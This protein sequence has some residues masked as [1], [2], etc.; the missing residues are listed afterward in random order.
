MRNAAALDDHNLADAARY[1]FRVWGNQEEVWRQLADMA[2]AEPK[3]RL[4]DCY[5]IGDDPSLNTK[6]RRSRLKVKHLREERLGFQRWSTSWH[7]LAEEAKEELLMAG[8]APGDPLSEDYEQMLTDTI[9]DLEWSGDVRPVLVTKHRRRFRV[10]S[11]RAESTT[12]MVDGM[13]KLLRTIAIEGYDLHD[14][15]HLRAVLGLEHVPNLPL[16]TAVNRFMLTAD[17]P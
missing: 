6:I 11:V 1:E 2:A 7:R 15:I 10:G 3:Q 13:S 5:L 4:A 16:H 14:L 8:A 9:D 17:E 12:V